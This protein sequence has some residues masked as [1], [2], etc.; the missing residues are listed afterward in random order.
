MPRPISQY[1]R[2]G[3][4]LRCLICG[5]NN[6]SRAEPALY[7]HERSHRHQAAAAEQGAIAAAIPKV[8]LDSSP[9]IIDN[10]GDHSA[11]IGP[12]V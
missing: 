6:L 5:K 4:G 9:E 7:G 3:A 12:E 2:D 10:T 8:P 1:V 11:K